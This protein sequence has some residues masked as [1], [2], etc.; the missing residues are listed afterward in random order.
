MTENMTIFG[1]GRQA[2]R[3][4]GRHNCSTL[5]IGCENENHVLL[6]FP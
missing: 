2:G 6:E 3:Q 5:F 4:A 1:A